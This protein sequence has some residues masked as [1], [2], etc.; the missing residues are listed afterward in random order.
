M[1]LPAEP[2][3]SVAC[4]DSSPRL[5]TVIGYTRVFANPDELA[6]RKARLANEGCGQVF[7]DDCRGAYPHRKGYEEALS[8]LVAGDCLIVHGL[9]EL[10]WRLEDLVQIT[11]DL[12]RWGVRLVA[13]DEGFDSES[14]ISGFTVIS[15][16]GL[17]SEAVRLQREAEGTR[18]D[19]RQKKHPRDFAKALEKVAAGEMSITEAA[20]TL[21]VHRSTLYRYRQDGSTK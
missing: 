4:R 11:R 13:L 1:S 20:D 17:Y 2:L 9:H 18:A 12:A 5:A 7:S 10:A 14:S 3:S 6:E 8:H 15:Q 19:P 16:L 21:G